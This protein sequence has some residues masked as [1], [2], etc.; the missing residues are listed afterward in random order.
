MAIRSTTPRGRICERKDLL[1]DIQA[2]LVQI[3]VGEEGLCERAAVE[4]CDQMSQSQVDYGDLLLQQEV[5]HFEQPLL[6]DTPSQTVD[7]S[8]C[9]YANA[10]YL[11]SLVQRGDPT[12]AT[13]LV[14][15]H[16]GVHLRVLEYA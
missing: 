9:L 8:S 4:P 12:A 7:N 14:D 16:A 15:Q 2:G 5:V 3:D 13:R 11:C 6:V 10:A 1:S